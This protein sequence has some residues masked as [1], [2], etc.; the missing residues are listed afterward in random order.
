VF[1]ETFQVNGKTTP[2]VVSLQDLNDHLRI[3]GAFSQLRSRVEQ[4]HAAT[5]AADI[6]PL[7]QTDAWTVFLCRAV[8]RFGLWLDV[9]KPVLS[10]NDGP[11]VGE[12][13][14][15]PLDVLMVWHSYMLV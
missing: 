10:P 4:V 7:S 11:T 14:L 13:K 12:M 9:V 3:L 6:F 15:P 2:P 5:R 1:P 8:Y